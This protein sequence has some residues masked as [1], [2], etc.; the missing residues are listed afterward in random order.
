MVGGIYAVLTY[1]QQSPKRRVTL[2]TRETKF[3]S[4]NVSDFK[5]ISISHAGLEVKD[6]RFVDVSVEATGRLD[7]PSERFDASHPIVMNCGTP[8]L[9]YTGSDAGSVKIGGDQR[10]LQVGPL[11]LKKGIPATIRLLI[12]GAASCSWEDPKLV[13][14]KVQI[15]SDTDEARFHARRSQRRQMTFLWITS[16]SLAISAL[17]FPLILERFR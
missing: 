9:A 13:D 11:L 5:D 1:R 4:A 8:I 14:T 17:W 7:V 3:I 6:P 16:S 10:S 2:S 15:V 12:D